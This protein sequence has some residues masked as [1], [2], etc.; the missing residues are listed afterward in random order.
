MQS[1][2][3]A[4]GV[5]GDPGAGL[6]T[7][8]RSCVMRDSPHLSLSFGGSTVPFRSIPKQFTRVFMPASSSL[9]KTPSLHQV[10]PIEPLA[11]SSVVSRLLAMVSPCLNTPL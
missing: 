6:S 4:F 8:P 2:S 10:P 3:A 11:K 1:S 5:G 9:E 7:L